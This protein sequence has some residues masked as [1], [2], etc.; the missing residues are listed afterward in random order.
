[1]LHLLDHPLAA[2]AVTRLRDKATPPA[3]FRRLAQVVGRSLALDATRHLPT[4]PVRVETP[5]ES[6]ESPRLAAPGLVVVPILRAG[7][8]L[9]PPFL[10]LHEDVTIGYIGLER[11]PGGTG[12]RQY[13]CK[14][15]P[16]ADRP[17]FVVDPML[18]TGASAVHALRLVKEQG[19]TAL[20]LVCIFAAPAGVAE[21]ERQHPDVAIHA[22]VLDRELSARNFILPGVG[23]FGD[24]L[25]G[26][27]A[28]LA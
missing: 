9:V 21:V 10:E 27:E 24:R 25:N 23:D 13:Y 3:A 1:M 12:T 16:L 17:V 5:L 26:T 4:R 2:D 15:P 18:A 19:A 22:A 7:Q 6:T 11:G 20:R 8:S 28:G 14:L